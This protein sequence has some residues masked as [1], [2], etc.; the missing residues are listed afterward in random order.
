VGLGEHEVLHCSG[1]E[2]AN[3]KPRW[4]TAV[5]KL[6]GRKILVLFTRRPGRVL[7]QSRI[8][9]YASE[10]QTESPSHIVE[11]PQKL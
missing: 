11:T 4:K 8:S 9:P 5:L 10:N 1:S 2:E 3:G 6:A 7:I